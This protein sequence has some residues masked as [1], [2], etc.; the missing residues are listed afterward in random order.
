MAKICQV[1]ISAPSKKEG[2]DIAASLVKK[3][4]IAGALITKGS[5]IYW[6]QNKIVK[7]VYYNINAFSVLS[8]KA[9][10]IREVKKIHTDK[11]PI[12]ALHEIDGNSEFLAWVMESIE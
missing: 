4:M 6:W 7:K 11:C 9:K 10:I 2:E 8:N 1:L 5:S 12:I 3:K